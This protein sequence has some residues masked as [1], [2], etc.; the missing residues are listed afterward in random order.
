MQRHVQPGIWQQDAKAD[1]NGDSSIFVFP[2]FKLVIKRAKQLI[3]LK[4]KHDRHDIAMV[5]HDQLQ[6]IPVRPTQDRQL[7]LP[8]VQPTWIPMN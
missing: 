4:T 2:T 6:R 3:D 5:W 8:W 1:R 7:Q